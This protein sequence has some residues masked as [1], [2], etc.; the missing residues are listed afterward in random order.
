MGADS[1]IEWCDHTFNPWFGCTRV[2]PAC[3][4]CYAEAWARRT[5]HPELWQ[6]ERRRTTGANW[7]LPLKWN[8]VAPLSRRP[9]VRWV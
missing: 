6:G 5:G 4:H 9:Q 3:D 7:L 2:S 1:K 8:K